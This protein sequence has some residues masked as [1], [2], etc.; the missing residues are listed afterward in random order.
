KVLNQGAP[1]YLVKL[2]LYI[3]INEIKSPNQLSLIGSLSQ[4][5][6]LQLEFQVLS[7]HP[8]FYQHLSFPHN[9]SC[10]ILVVTDSPE[11]P[12]KYNLEDFL[13]FAKLSKLK[14]FNFTY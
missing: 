12:R 3:R 5:T 10:L 14:V 6:N 2:N 4:V 8:L 1:K 9:L 7:G 13:T 11:S